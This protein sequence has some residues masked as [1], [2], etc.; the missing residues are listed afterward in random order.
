LT[1]TTG[2]VTAALLKLDYTPLPYLKVVTTGGGVGDLTV[3]LTDIP[4]AVNKGYTLISTDTGHPFD[5]GPII[6]I[7]PSQTMFDVLAFTPSLGNPLAWVTGAP[8][9]LY[10]TSPF[11]VPTGTLA[12][13]A[14]QTWDFVTLALNDTIIP[15]VLI[16]IARSNVVR[17]NF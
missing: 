7:Y 10:P 17:V 14:G 5:S 13:L 4:A 9:G 1:G 8:S 2:L 11:F 15:G 3:T 6:G 16:Y 12:F